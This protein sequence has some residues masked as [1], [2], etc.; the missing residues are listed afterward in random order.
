[1]PLPKSDARWIAGFRSKYAEWWPE[2]RAL[3][4]G[5]QYVA[6][7]K[8]Y[9]WPSFDSSP[10]VPVLKPL[11]RSRL[12]VVTTGGLYRPGLD[13]PFESQALEGAWS[14]RA[15]SRPVNL[16]RLAIAHLHFPHE[17]AQADMNAIFPLDRLTELEESGIIGDLAPTH[18]SMMG[19]C[20]RADE[21]AEKT[22]QVGACALPPREHAGRAGEPREA[23]GRV[24]CRV[25][26]VGSDQ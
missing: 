20:T 9:P 5:H 12:A 3:L 1:M 7:F 14:Y 10:W 22:A 11:D 13:A 24:A 2:A 15:L 8:A 16:S 23:D 17:V 4:E 26:G 25:R 21:V 18:Y 19:F 6:A